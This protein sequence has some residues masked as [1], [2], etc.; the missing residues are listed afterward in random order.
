MPGMR[1]AD[2][3]VVGFRDGAGVVHG[4]H[5]AES[6]FAAAVP[7]VRRAAERCGF[8]IRL[9]ANGGH[10][11]AKKPDNGRE[12]EI[13]PPS[14]TM[15]T[16]VWIFGFPLLLVLAAYLN[17]SW[18]R[19]GF[20]PVAAAYGIFAAALLGF[21]LLITWSYFRCYRAYQTQIGEATDDEEEDSTLS[22]AGEPEEDVEE[23]N[24]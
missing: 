5:A 11:R 20:G 16:L 9:L 13:E 4:M 1:F 15:T 24:V 10:R 21:I 2:S 3:Q 14:A 19:D 23:E 7:A 12:A 17:E 18:D 22:A 8:D 6:S